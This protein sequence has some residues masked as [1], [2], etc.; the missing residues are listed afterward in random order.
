MG[1]FGGSFLNHQYLDLCLRARPIRMRR[2]LNAGAGPSITPA[3]APMLP[4]ACAS[5]AAARSVAPERARRRSAL[6]GPPVFARSGS[7]TPKNYFGDGQLPRRQHDAAGRTS[8][9]PTRLPCQTAAM[10][11]LRAIRHCPTTLAAADHGPTIGDAARRAGS[12]QL[13]LVR[14]RL[15]RRAGRRACA[16]RTRRASVIYAPETPRGSPDFQPHHQPF[17]Y[18]AEV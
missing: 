8:P 11:A 12:V 6:D 9:A 14:R 15:E 7:L 1:A 4:G 10:P 3:R 5:V 16:R 2:A 18:Y 13:G 17:N